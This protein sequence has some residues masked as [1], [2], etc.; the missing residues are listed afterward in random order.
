MDFVPLAPGDSGGVGRPDTAGLDLLSAGQQF[1]GTEA[2][3]VGQASEAPIP[4]VALAGLDT[5]VFQTTSPNLVYTTPDN[6][7]V[8][9]LHGGQGAPDGPG[10]GHYIY[11]PIKDQV[12]QD[13]P[14]Q[15]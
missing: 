2:E 7:Q 1:G 12:I 3:P 8:H 13:R 4:G 14:P 6:G 11:S 9:I 15:S 5:R 10:H